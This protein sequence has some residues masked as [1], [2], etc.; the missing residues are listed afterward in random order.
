MEYFGFM[1]LVGST[2][3]LAISPAPTAMSS[4][5]PFS[6]LPRPA[7]SLQYFG[8]TQLAERTIHPWRAD[9]HARIVDAPGSPTN[10]N[11]GIHEVSVLL[12]ASFSICN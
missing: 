2:P 11:C 12:L 9:H 5:F 1:G 4:S 6:C 10:Q 3:C 8:R 7:D